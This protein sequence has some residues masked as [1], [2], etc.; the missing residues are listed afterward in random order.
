MVMDLRR[1]SLAD[2]PLMLDWMQ[3]KEIIC[4][5]Q[6]DFSN[7]SLRDAE[8]FIQSSWVDDRN[9]HYAIVNDIDE[10]MG[11]VSLKHINNNYAE[12][13]IVVRREAMGKGYAWFGMSSMISK[14]FSEYGLTCIYWCVSETNNRAIRFYRKHGFCEEVDIPPELLLLYGDMNKIKWFSVKRY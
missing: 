3:D 9:A 4:N 10:Y 5:L 11:T 14:G 7:Y 6:K 8:L 13:A 2:A 12:F 1:L